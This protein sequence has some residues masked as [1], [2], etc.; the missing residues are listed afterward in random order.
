MLDQVLSSKH[1]NIIQKR[2]IIL[3]GDDCVFKSYDVRV[4]DVSTTVNKKHEAGV[5]SIRSHIDK[6]HQLLTGRFVLATLYTEVG[7]K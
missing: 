5:T 6:E 4:P 7:C 2:P 3:G 1:L